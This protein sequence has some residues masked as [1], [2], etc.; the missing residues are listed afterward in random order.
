MANINYRKVLNMIH[1][2]ITDVE[3]V[4]LELSWIRKIWY[5]IVLTGTSIYVFSNFSELVNFTF[6]NQFNGKNLIF[7]LWLAL[8]LIPLVDNFEGFGVRFNTHKMI[9]SNRISS[10]LA[11]NVLKNGQKTSAELKK[12]MEKIISK[13]KK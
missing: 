2:F 5:V 10:Q 11:D 3:R 1:S 8:I 13:E 6:F 12:E 9:E 4:E 7:I